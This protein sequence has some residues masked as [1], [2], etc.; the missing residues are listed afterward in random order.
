VVFYGLDKHRWKD[1]K[2]LLNPCR[3]QPRQDDANMSGKLKQCVAWAALV[4][5]LS[6]SGLSWDL[7]QLT[8]Y[9]NMSAA[10]A[11]TMSG[12]EAL[13]RTLEEAPC[14]LCLA[15]REGRAKSE[16]SPAQKDELAKVK[17]KADFADGV[18]L[19]A[20]AEFGL[21]RRFQFPADETAVGLTDK[22]PVPPPRA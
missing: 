12:A 22:V 17:I 16:S 13:T 3:T 9:V 18:T 7:L 19:L 15:A 14:P 1:A 11:R 10:N 2:E 6:A 8:A 4:A 20:V 21:G 5:W